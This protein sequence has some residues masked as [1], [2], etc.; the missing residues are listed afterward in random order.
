MKTLSK[1][2]NHKEYINKAFEKKQ[3]RHEMKKKCKVSF[4]ISGRITSTPFNL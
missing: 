4:I 3:I 2:I 1:Q